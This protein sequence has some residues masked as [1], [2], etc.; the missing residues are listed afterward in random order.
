MTLNRNRND[1]GESW[2]LWRR[3]EDLKINGYLWRKPLAA[4]RKKK[5]ESCL[6]VAGG[7]QS[8]KSRAAANQLAYG[9]GVWHMKAGAM[10]LS[11][12]AIGLSYGISMK[13]AM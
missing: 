7:G 13:L 12:V 4:Y 5:L 8:A 10:P 9:N 1:R 2:A 3:R 11:V 6:S